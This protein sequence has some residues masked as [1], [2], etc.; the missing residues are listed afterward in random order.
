[1]GNPLFALALPGYTWQYIQYTFI[2]NKYDR[3]KSKKIMRRE[4]VDSSVD[5]VNFSVQK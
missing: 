3:N 1:M 5:L 2:Y 4:L